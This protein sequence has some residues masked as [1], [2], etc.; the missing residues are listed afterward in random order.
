MRAGV[1]DHSKQVMPGGACR[2]SSPGTDSGTD[3]LPTD[4]RF[5]TASSG[6]VEFDC[7]W[8]TLPTAHLALPQGCMLHLLDTELSRVLA[9]SVL[10]SR[11]T[12]CWKL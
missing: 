9:G 8:Q 10:L 5:V 1:S 3:S 7:S 4:R 6:S 2:L 12:F 11:Y